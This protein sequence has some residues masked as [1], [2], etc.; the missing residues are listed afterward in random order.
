MK[1]FTLCDAHGILVIGETPFVGFVKSHYTNPTIR[2]GKESDQEMITRDR[3][4][5]SIAWSLA[6]EGILVRSRAILQ[7]HV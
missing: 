7:R 3:N 2:K 5:P 6:N 4:H 1:N